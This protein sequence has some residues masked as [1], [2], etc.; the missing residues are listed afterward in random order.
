MARIRWFSFSVPI[1]TPHRCQ[2]GAEAPAHHDPSVIE[3]N[4]R[5]RPYETDGTSNSLYPWGAALPFD[6]HQPVRRM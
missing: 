6:R 3:S 5:I 2:V 4:A 1:P